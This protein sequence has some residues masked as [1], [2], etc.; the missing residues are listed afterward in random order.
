MKR[1]ATFLMVLVVC[2]S[3]CACGQT[4]ALEPKYGSQ[5][6]YDPPIPATTRPFEAYDAYFLASEFVHAF[7][8]CCADKVGYDSVE[9]FKVGS[10]KDNGDDGDYYYFT[11]Y[12][13]FAG[14]DKYGSVKGF[15]KFEWKI[16]VRMNDRDGDWVR[17]D[18]IS[19]SALRS[20]LKVT[21]D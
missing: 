11:F 2:L 10:Y 3:L 13:T 9:Y 8:D 20:N 7:R 16:K 12:G 4:S 21:R 15:Y 18:N 6:Q 17:L 1:T 19:D 14:V 5:T